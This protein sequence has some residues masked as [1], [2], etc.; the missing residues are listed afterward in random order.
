[1]DIPSAMTHPAARSCRLA[2]LLLVSVPMACGY[3]RAPAYPTATAKD[4]GFET[5][6]LDLPGLPNDAPPPFALQPGDT[7]SVELVSTEVREVP[8]VMLDATGAVHLPPVGDVWLKGASL[9]EAE[10]MIAKGMQQYDRLAQ[11]RI[12][13]AGRGGQR[14]TVLGA[15]VRQGPVELQPAARITDVIAA[16]EGPLTAQTGPN[17]VPVAD[18]AGAVV[19][20]GDKK[21]P[22]D[23]ALA[24]RGD[25]KHNVYVR[26]GDH[27]YL[28]PS[29]GSHITVLGQV[30]APQ[31]FAYRPGLRLTQALALASGVTVGADK[32]DIRVIRGTL[33]QPKVYRA[34]LRD[35][36]D[37]ESHDVLLQPGDIIFVTDHAIED[38]A[39]VLTV[40]SPALSL[41]LSSVALALTLQ[42]N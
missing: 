37:G 41:G 13:L 28:P 40:I 35:V 36:V 14:A 21:L 34:S 19:M 24:L 5:K 9:S 26:P 42:N 32:D 23:M 27:I 31:L 2:T 33:A 16:A 18:L 11:V 29:T 1:M 38:I 7:I 22:I 4:E 20:R 8:D 15:V 10:A 30:G 12:R 25:P 3:P 39:E 17:P 6:T